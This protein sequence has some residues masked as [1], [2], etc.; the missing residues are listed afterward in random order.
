[1]TTTTMMMVMIRMGLE[2]G[3]RKEKLP[4]RGGGGN[5]KLFATSLSRCLS[6]AL[7]INFEQHEFFTIRT[8]IKCR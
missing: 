4:Q 3:A 8:N 6:V 2:K 1:M 7:K 5:W